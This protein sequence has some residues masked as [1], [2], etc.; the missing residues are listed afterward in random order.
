MTPCGHIGKGPDARRPAGER[1]D[2]E[3]SAGTRAVRVGISGTHKAT[4]RRGVIPEASGNSAQRNGAGPGGSRTSAI[5]I[6]LRS[7]GPGDSGKS[8]PKTAPYARPPDNC[9]RAPPPGTEG[10]GGGRVGRGGEDADRQFN[11][12]DRPLLGIRR[13]ACSY[14][15][16]SDRR[17]E[18]HGGRPGGGTRR[19]TSNGGSATASRMMRSSAPVGPSVGRTAC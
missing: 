19:G 9:S 11:A 10:Q 17:Q 15:A 4:R 2:G 16:D 1:S 14:H 5:R 13:P 12:V 6:L 8:F 7:V 3:R 18:R